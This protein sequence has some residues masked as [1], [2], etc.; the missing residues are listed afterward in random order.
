MKFSRLWVVLAWCCVVGSQARAEVIT[1]ATYNVEN[2]R[3]HYSARSM[4]TQPAVKGNPDMKEYVDL[5]RK[6]ND[7]DNWETAMVIM[8][9][10]LNPDVIVFQEAAEQKDLD[11]FNRRWL[12]GMYETVIQ[13]QTNT[14]Y[15]QHMAIMLK[16]GFEVLDKR[17]FYKDPDT[18]KNERGENL[19]ARGPAFVL[20]QT[21]AGFQMW[22]GTTHQKSKR[23][24]DIDTTK[25]RNR[26]ATR[27]HE[28]M[29]ELHATGHPVLLLGDCNDEWGL[30]EFE[31]EG[32]GDV[33]GN[34][35]GPEKDGYV[36]LTKPLVDAGKI[37]FGGYN[38]EDHR[39]F[40]DHV[41]ASPD[42]KSR[43]VDIDVFQ[44]GVAKV[45]SDHYPVY[46]KLRTADEPPA[47][48]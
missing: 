38:R 47:K 4:T 1:V 32:G 6:E 19:F 15:T 42:L 26:E 22:I 48:P 43:V 37:S 25:W 31:Q 21:P 29:K 5:M 36:L 40:I 33:I 13:F 34:L 8:D 2:W 18:E 11:S 14:N 41:V 46:V 24:N 9:P 35:L 44:D 30:Q 12:K 45:A 7:E 16:P 23:G 3:T 39:S 17:E 20:V 27:T 10:K 28:I